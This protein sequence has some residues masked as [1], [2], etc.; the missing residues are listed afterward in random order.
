MYN[1]IHLLL[2]RRCKS[3]PALYIGDKA[4][5]KLTALHFKYKH[6]EDVKIQS[7]ITEK[8]WSWLRNRAYM[9]FRTNISVACA[10]KKNNKKQQIL[11]L[12]VIILHLIKSYISIYT[13]MYIQYV[14]NLGMET[15]GI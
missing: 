10:G 13:C 7:Q 14:I 12:C 6:M 15:P 1:Q 3:A 11:T 2:K 9:G 5:A 4:L 8:I